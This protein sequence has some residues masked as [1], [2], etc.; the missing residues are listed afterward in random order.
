M[1]CDESVYKILFTLFQLLIY[2]F[3]SVYLFMPRTSFE[4]CVEL[5][6]STLG[7]WIDICTM[8]W[9][10]IILWV[11]SPS[12]F[13]FSPLALY[14]SGCC[15]FKWFYFILT[16]FLPKW[17]SLSKLYDVNGKN[18]ENSEMKKFCF[19]VSAWQW[20]K[21]VFMATMQLNNKTS[22][23]TSF[24]IWDDKLITS[25]V[26]DMIPIINRAWFEKENNLIRLSKSI[27]CSYQDH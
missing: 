14:F 19:L 1:D 7:D 27:D 11:I 16:I 10:G 26:G 6:P 12:S 23:Q 2:L 4:I 18:T 3:S 22:P 5:F 24:F 8:L 20:E 17:C 21:K 15:T 9:L 13:F 25:I